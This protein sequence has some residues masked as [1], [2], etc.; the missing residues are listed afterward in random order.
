MAKTRGHQSNMR[1]CM[2]VA[3]RQAV[4]TFLSEMELVAKSR[5]RRQRRKAC[6]KYIKHCDVSVFLED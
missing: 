2:T 1:R 4:L 3:R 6:R 5:T